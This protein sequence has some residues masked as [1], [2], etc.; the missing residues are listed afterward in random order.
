MTSSE[1]IVTALIW[2]LTAAG[3]FFSI[4][5]ILRRRRQNR[6]TPAEQPGEAQDL[7]P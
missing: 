1:I 3:G 6:A 5:G 7:R 2:A 4:R